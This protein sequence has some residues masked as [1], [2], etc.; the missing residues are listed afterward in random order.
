M[1]PNDPRIEESTCKSS[2]TQPGNDKA[3]MQDW[4]LNREGNDSQTRGTCYQLM[5]AIDLGATKINF[6]IV[7]DA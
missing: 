5:K 4:S 6:I 3:W 1:T 2:E 7:F